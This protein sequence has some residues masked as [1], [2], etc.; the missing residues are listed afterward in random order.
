MTQ[1]IYE[2]LA[3]QEIRQII[4]DPDG[5]L[6]LSKVVEE[7]RK[8]KETKEYAIYLLQKIADNE[9]IPL[10]NIKKLLQE[11]ENIQSEYGQLKTT[12]DNLPAR[13]ELLYI[14]AENN[15]QA[16]V[17]IANALYKRIHKGS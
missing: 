9:D 12:V 4:G 6:M 16:G 5:K 17:D 8:L 14:L 7:I 3:M 13:D 1:Q 10:W 2:L 11:P 15:V